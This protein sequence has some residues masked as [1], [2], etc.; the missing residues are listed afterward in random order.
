MVTETGHL[1]AR[2]LNNECTINARDWY[3]VPTRCTTVTSSENVRSIDEQTNATARIKQPHEREAPPYLITPEASTDWNTNTSSKTE[4]LELQGNLDTHTHTQH[5]TKRRE[6]CPTMTI[7]DE[8]HSKCLRQVLGSVSVFGS[9]PRVQWRTH[10]SLPR[11]SLCLRRCSCLESSSR[12]TTAAPSDS[13][14]VATSHD[15]VT[16]HLRRY[17]WQRR[18]RSEG[19]AWGQ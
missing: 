2:H 5:T 18:Y 1:H 9:C 3:P 12:T 8:L 19:S 11:P 15:L 7:R 14:S 4:Q 10:A 16:E 17:K 13:P 6:A